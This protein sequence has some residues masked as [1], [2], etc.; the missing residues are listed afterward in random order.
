[1]F[2]PYSP[3]TGPFWDRID[4]L[5]L[6]SR[7]E[8]GPLVTLEAIQYG[9][10]V[11]ATDVGSVTE[12]I[13]GEVGIVVPPG[14]VDALVDAMSCLASAPGMRARMREAALSR[15]ATAWSSADM[16]SAYDRLYREVM[17]RH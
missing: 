15:A 4:V 8:A 6:P 13:D 9:R 14:D 11:I 1:V 5:T 17:Q 12:I 10:P 2:S 3:D 7:S 16:A